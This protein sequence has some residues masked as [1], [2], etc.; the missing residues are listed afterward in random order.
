MPISSANTTW[1]EEEEDLK[2]INRCKLYN[3]TKYNVKV[4]TG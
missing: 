4:N 1:Y 3:H 2:T